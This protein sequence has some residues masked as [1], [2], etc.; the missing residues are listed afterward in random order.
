MAQTATII[1]G[2]CFVGVITWTILLWSAQRFFKIFL[3]VSVALHALLFIIPFATSQG[4]PDT[5]GPL[6]VPF[7]I[8]QGTDEP[9]TDEAAVEPLDEE[10]PDDTIGVADT[11][12]N[13]PLTEEAVNVETKRASPPPGT[14]EPGVPEITNLTWYTFETHP[15]AASYR[16]ELQRIVQRHFEV[17]AELDER[18]YEGRV[19]VWLSLSRDGRLNY[20]FIDANVRSQEWAINQLTEANVKRIAGE[21]PPFPEGVKDYDVT[22]YI[23]IDYRNLRHR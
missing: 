10:L 7:T 12:T 21:F 20:S 2:L 3:T 5:P 11:P 9:V 19:K 14:V 18:G 17:P 13:D 15:G 23:I 1:V 16:K 6:L 4:E 8:V 22:F